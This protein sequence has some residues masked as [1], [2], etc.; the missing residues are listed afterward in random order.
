MRM[1][2]KILNG[3]LFHVLEHLVTKP[4][5]GSLSYHQEYA[6]LRVCKYNAKR[7]IDGNP[8]HGV[9][10]SCIIGPPGKLILSVYDF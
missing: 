9:E 1:C 2:V 10:Q 3:E 6:G 7:I 4:F 8:L 5:H